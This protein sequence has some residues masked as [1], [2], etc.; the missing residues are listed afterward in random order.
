MAQNGA[1]DKLSH[2]GQRTDPEFRRL[3]RGPV[4]GQ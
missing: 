4:A 2:P 1:E 3:E